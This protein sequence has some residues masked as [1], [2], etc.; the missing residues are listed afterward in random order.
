MQFTIG[1]EG[2][3]QLRR[4]QAMLRREIPTGD[5][6]LIFE[7]ALALLHAHVQKSKLGVGARPGTKRSKRPIRPGADKRTRPGG[8]ETEPA[9]AGRGLSFRPAA[10]SRHIPIDVKRTVW[11]RDRGQCAFVSAG[12]RQ[13]TERNFLELHHIHPYAMDGPATV[14]NISLRCRRHNQYEAEIA[15]GA[16]IGAYAANRARHMSSSELTLRFG[17]DS[18]EG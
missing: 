4:L 10:S 12:G 11:W 3:D 8:S 15:F 1:Q 16:H 5:A 6:G 7:H 17:K 13:C 18:G 14:G 2:Y 9:E